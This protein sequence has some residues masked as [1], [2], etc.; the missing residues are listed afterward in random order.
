MKGK[1]GRSI[2][3]ISDVRAAVLRFCDEQLSRRLD[4]Q[5]VAE[6]HQKVSACVQT[7]DP[8]M[9][10]YIFGS[11]AVLGV[12]EQGSDVDFVCLSPTDVQ[13]GK[14][15]DAVSE[16]AKG[17]QSDF[18]F[19]LGEVVKR[20]HY[21]WGI[22]LVRRTRVPVLRVK[23]GLGVDG[24]SFDVT[25]NRRNGVRNSALLRAYFT[26]CPEA[27]WLSMLVKQWSKKTGLNASVEGGCITSY[28]WNIMIVYYLLRRRLVTLVPVESCD[29]ADIAPMPPHMPLESLQQGGQ[30]LADMLMDFVSYY[31][32]EFAPETEVMSLTRAAGETTTEM[33]SWTKQAEDMARIRGEKIHYRWCIEDPYE[34]DLNVGRNVTPFKLMLLRKHLERARET[35]LLLLATP[36]PSA[37]ARSVK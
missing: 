12:H 32:D 3:A 28:G 10:P 22:E 25:A 34:Y 9:T 8:A 31:L 35:A 11:T 4:T 21:L 16:V 2:A 5:P 13:D 15:A 23:G 17:L 18:L 36:P 26:Q 1:A 33:L 37:T 19:R 29:V 6:V 14:G 24:V 30:G 20:E 27:R 7:V